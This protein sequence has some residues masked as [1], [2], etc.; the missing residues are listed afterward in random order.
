VVVKLAPE[1]TRSYATT[2]C[3]CNGRE[4]AVVWSIQ[5]QHIVSWC[6]TPAEAQQIAARLNAPGK[7]RP[8]ASFTKEV[9][10]AVVHSWAG[11]RSR[12]IM[13]GVITVLAVRT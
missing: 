1:V 10:G 11:I 4:L 7:P 6:A 2:T 13:L 9:C 12:L 5:G 3:E 8:V